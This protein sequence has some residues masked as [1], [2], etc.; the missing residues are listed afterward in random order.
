MKSFDD[1]ARALCDEASTVPKPP[2]V[3]SPVRSLNDGGKPSAA[4]G[5]LNGPPTA[6]PSNTI[7]CSLPQT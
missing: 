7:R 3:A 6:I 2:S 4:L 1:A 5:M